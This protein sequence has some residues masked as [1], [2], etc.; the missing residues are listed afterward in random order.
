MY[1]SF[2]Y[3][4]NKFLTVFEEYIVS[5]LL[6]ETILYLFGSMKISFNNNDTIDDFRN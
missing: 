1:G 5:K 3:Y 4:G 2:T 6:N